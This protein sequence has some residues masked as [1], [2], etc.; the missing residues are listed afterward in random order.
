MTECES[1]D[2]LTHSINIFVFRG[3]VGALSNSKNLNTVNT[4]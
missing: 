2:K 1:F 3:Y 4:E